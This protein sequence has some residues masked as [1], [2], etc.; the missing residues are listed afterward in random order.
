METETFTGNIKLREDNDGLVDQV[1]GV[2]AKTDEIP[3]PVIV[4]MVRYP[5][6]KVTPPV[7]ADPIEW[8]SGLTAEYL[9][10]LPKAGSQN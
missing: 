3:F 5:A 7:G 6:A 8:I 4:D 2:T 1:V 9:A 10:D